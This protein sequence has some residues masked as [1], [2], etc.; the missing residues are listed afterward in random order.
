MKSSFL[1]RKLS[2]TVA[3]DTHRYLKHLIQSGRV[4]TI[5]EAIDWVV[6]RA[7]HAENRARLERDTAA[8]FAGLP[9]DEAA[10]EARLEAALARSVDEVRFDE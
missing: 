10:E 8:Y 7:R 6:K 5:A 1:R 3:P 4:H 2:T 9:A